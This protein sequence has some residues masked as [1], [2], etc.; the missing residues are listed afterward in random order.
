MELTMTKELA[1][2]VDR[3]I[4]YGEEK[5]HIPPDEGVSIERLR[6]IACI[7]PQDKLE[8]YKRSDIPFLISFCIGF[9]TADYHILERL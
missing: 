6:T 3:W 8:D 1:L 7:L 2:T 4:E 9:A 5:L